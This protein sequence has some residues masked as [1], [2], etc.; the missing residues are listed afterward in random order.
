MELYYKFDNSIGRVRHM[1]TFFLQGVIFKAN[2]GIKNDYGI[3][4]DLKEFP[5]LVNLLFQNGRQFTL[6]LKRNYTINHF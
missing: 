3:I 5:I 2:F 6:I 4:F 1:T